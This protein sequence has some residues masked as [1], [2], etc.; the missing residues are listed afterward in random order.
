M[1]FNCPTSSNQTLGY[2]LH[3]LIL[4]MSKSFTFTHIS[5]RSKLE[6]SFLRLASTQSN[7]G[8]LR[9]LRAKPSSSLSD[10]SPRRF[11][12][13]SLIWIYFLLRTTAAP[14]RAHYLS[15]LVTLS[16]TEARTNIPLPK[17]PSAQ[18]S[19]GLLL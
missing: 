18:V 3:F 6:G 11:L 15:T 14:S 7:G 10:T 12:Y 5:V 16:S 4:E 13:G 2:N 8:I 19:S 17:Q 9:M 1:S